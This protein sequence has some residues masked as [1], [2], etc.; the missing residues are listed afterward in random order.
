MSF[1]NEPRVVSLLSACSEIVCR[2]GMAHCLV[3]RSHGCD[4]PEL[5]KAVPAVT[6]PYVDPSAPSAELDAQVRAQSASGG[7]VYHL[8]R[9]RII[10]L[11]PD[12]VITQRQCR[13]CA[14][15]DKDL[16]DACGRDEASALGPRVR[17]VTVEP[18]TLDDVMAD[19]LR[20]AEALGVPERGEALVGH[21]RNR[22]ADVAAASAAALGGGAAPT[23]AHVEWLS[24]VMGS[25]YWIAELIEAAGG[26]MVVGEKGGHAPTVS[27]GALSEAD[28]ILLAP[29]GFSIERTAAELAL[30]GWTTNE[31]WLALKAVRAGRVYVADGNR[32]F[33]R[34]ST[35]VVDSAE[36]V[37][38]CVHPQLCGR[39]AHHGERWVRLGEL[40]AYAARRSAPPVIVAK[41]ALHEAAADAAVALPLPSRPAPPPPAAD[42]PAESVVLAQCLALQAGDA[43]AAFALNTAANAG[44][45]GSA[46]AF[47]AIVAGSPSF[48]SL[49]QPECRFEATAEPSAAAA[50]ADEATVRLAVC[51]GSEAPPGG[52]LLFDLR[53]DAPTAPWRTERVRPC[54]C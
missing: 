18:T 34:S 27:L 38:E 33:N 10:A 11:Q 52:A 36:I 5:V 30:L 8:E 43:A 14:V 12:V 48:S 44:R 22:L 21:L 6:A 40:P 49:L 19:V 26:R 9:E 3:G 46:R 45:L 54:V 51:G 4:A 42:A 50:T 2:L 20:I 47:W 24:P 1:P 37:A 35:A 17:V 13:I 15:T 28:M 23:V 53:R 7:P 41:R 16:H 32:H 29:C 25:G 31:E 39:W